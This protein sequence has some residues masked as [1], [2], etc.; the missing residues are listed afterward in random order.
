MTTFAGQIILKGQKILW[1]IPQ[2][3]QEKLNEFFDIFCIRRLEAVFV[4]AHHFNCKLFHAVSIVSKHFGFCL[5][6]EKLH[7]FHLYWD[8]QWKREKLRSSLSL[9]LTL[10]LGWVRKWN[11]LVRVHVA[12]HDAKNRR[13]RKWSPVSPEMIGNRCRQSA[14]YCFSGTIS[15][16]ILANRRF[17]KHDFTYVIDEICG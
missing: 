10:P 11:S 3:I 17:P 13:L 1:P 9:T 7:W 8:I 15:S 14:K 6:S 12:T 4:S 5:R 16:P 2:S